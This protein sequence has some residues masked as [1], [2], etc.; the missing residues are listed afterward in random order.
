M[1]FGA[2][3][4]V[5]GGSLVGGGLGG[6]EGPGFFVFAEGLFL[7]F[8]QA[9]GFSSER[10]AVTLNEA[11]DNVSVSRVISMYHPQLGGEPVETELSDKKWVFPGKALEEIRHILRP[12]QP[13][14]A[15]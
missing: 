10:I 1:L 13:G 8:V 14:D 9:G 2:G 6:E 5:G 7:S 11:G 4:P 12:G 15:T 3:D